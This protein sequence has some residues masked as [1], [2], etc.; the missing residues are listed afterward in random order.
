MQGGLGHGWQETEH[1]LFR[2]RMPQCADRVEVRL[3]PGGERQLA[4]D[5]LTDRQIPRPLG[6]QRDQQIEPSPA[7]VVGRG[8]RQLAEHRPAAG[9]EDR[10]DLVGRNGVVGERESDDGGDVLVLREV[11]APV[12][13]AQTGHDRSAEQ[14]GVCSGERRQ[15]SD[16]VASCRVPEEFQAPLPQC[17]RQAGVLGDLAQ[18]VRVSVPGRCG[19]CGGG[20]LGPGRGRYGGEER[21]EARQRERFERRPRLGEFAQRPGHDAGAAPAEQGG[22]PGAHQRRPQQSGV[23]P[24]AEQTQRLAL[25]HGVVG[26][27]QFGDQPF[28][29]VCSSAR[30]SRSA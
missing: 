10:R 1:R 25:H 21:R 27:S 3:R 18:Q 4:D 7:P 22:Q 20:H 30:V 5:G 9:E 29:P 13:G 28:G 12:Q 23:Q 16:V 8:L 15:C 19:E 11:S 26:F 17:G 6:G 14:Q 2:V 24:F